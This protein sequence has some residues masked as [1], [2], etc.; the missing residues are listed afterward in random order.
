MLQG[1]SL[2][3]RIDKNKNESTE[4][5]ERGRGEGGEGKGRG[6]DEEGLHAEEYIP[7]LATISIGQDRKNTIEGSSATDK[8]YP[9]RQNDK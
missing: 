9:T 1:N 4:D 2:W 5:G 6:K 3:S 8:D 7:C